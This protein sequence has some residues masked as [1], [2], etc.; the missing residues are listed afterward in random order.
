MTKVCNEDDRE[1]HL[2]SLRNGDLNEREL[3]DNIHLR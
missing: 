3:I 1:G 2:Y